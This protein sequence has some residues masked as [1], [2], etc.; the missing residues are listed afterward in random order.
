MSRSRKIS[1]V[2]SSS[3]ANSRIC[4]TAHVGG[5]FPIDVARAFEGFVGADAIEVAA[6][7]AVVGF[8]FAGDAGEQI[9]EAGLG[10]D[11]GVDDHFAA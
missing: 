11:R 3:R 2:C 10:I 1:T 5:G 8:D 6:E 4:K 9:V 7:S